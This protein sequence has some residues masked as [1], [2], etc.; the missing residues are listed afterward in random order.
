[1]NQANTLAKAALIGAL[2]RTQK[3]TIMTGIQGLDAITDGLRPGV[4]VLGG[5]PGIGKT[6][7]AMQIA[8]SAA[9]S[10]CP[11]VYAAF[12]EDARRML[13]R[14]LACAHNRARG[15]EWREHVIPAEYERPGGDLSHVSTIIDEQA[16]LLARI[17]CVDAYPHW[18]VEVLADTISGAMA[19]KRCERGLLVIDPI[20]SW[21]DGWGMRHK[22]EDPETSLMSEVQR[23]ARS[24]GISVLAISS[25]SV[26]GFS[27]SATEVLWMDEARMRDLP[28]HEL[29]EAERLRHEHGI[30]LRYVSVNV[31]K[32]RYG[33]GGEVLLR[34]YA[35]R[36]FFEEV[37]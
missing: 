7:L 11:V 3:A 9:E 37:Q 20:Q 24:L 15:H 33:R 27:Y 30:A 16:E 8:A 6:Q 5:E 17:W 4:Y 28:R 22:T 10:G 18:K 14:I 36:C 34:H 13:L 2:D 12:E 35:D 31:S 25:S 23:L 1:M 26:C 32:N 19:Q 21:A 29:K